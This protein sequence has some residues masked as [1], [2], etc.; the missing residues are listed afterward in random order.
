MMAL[1]AGWMLVLETALAAGMDPPAIH[2]LRGSMP[3]AKE[4]FSS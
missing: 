3:A 2:V 1:P 4:F